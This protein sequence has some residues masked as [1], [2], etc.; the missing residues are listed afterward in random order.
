MNMQ[1]GV[2]K[3]FAL[4]EL[5][6]SRFLTEDYIYRTMR[7]DIV[8]YMADNDIAPVATH[9]YQKSGWCDLID[10]VCHYSLNYAYD[11]DQNWIIKLADIP[12]N[13]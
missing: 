6:Q 12:E 5:E 13:K 1:L 4:E 3:K 8:K 7:S 2:V 11:P 9:T 10:K